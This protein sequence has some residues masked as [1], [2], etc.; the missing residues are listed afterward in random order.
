MPSP[1]STS[2][3]L[4]S[5]EAAAHPGLEVLSIGVW[6]AEPL[7]LAPVFGLSRLRTLVAY[8]RYARRSAGDRRTHRPGVPGD[9]S[10]GMARPPGRGRRPARPVGRRRQGAR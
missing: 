10:G 7:S 4:P 6:D 2:G 8:P 5:I 3:S 9:R 1:T